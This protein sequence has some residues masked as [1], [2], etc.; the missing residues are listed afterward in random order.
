VADAGM[1][2]ANMVAAHSE[3]ATMTLRNFFM[4]NLRARF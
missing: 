3:I 2:M 4:M 1:T